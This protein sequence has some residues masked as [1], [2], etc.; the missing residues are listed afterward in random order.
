MISLDYLVHVGAF[1]FLIAYLVRDQ[2][3]LR[4]LI[5]IGTIF[6]IIYYLLLSEPLWSALGWNSLFVLINCVMIFLIY[7]D[8][9]KFSMSED[10]E[11]LFGL[12]NTLSPGEFRKLMKISEWVVAEEKILIT[13]LDEVPDKLYFILEGHAE[14]NRINKKFK[15]GPGVFIGELAFLTKN[16]ATAD[17]NLMQNSKSICW[18]TN[19]LMGLLTRNPQMKIAFDALLNKDLAAK[20]TNN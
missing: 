7:A 4:A 11:K 14:I 9:A 2:I 1:I 3:L 10:E 19:R 12:F 8:R 20:L 15:V 16:T 6:Y 18:E 17:V 5:V 13:K